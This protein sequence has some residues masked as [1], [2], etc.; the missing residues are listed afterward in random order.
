MSDQA[1]LWT[2]AETLRIQAGQVMAELKARGDDWQT[3]W[4]THPVAIAYRK[5]L[6]EA[7]RQPHQTDDPRYRAVLSTPQE[8][9]A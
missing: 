3:A 9:R 7:W 1:D 2:R 8:P 5:L 4:K 6:A